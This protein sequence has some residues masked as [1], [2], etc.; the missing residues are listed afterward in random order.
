MLYRD[1]ADNHV[2]DPVY[3]PPNEDLHF[4]NN[5]VVDNSHSR[6]D[7]FVTLSCP[8]SSTANCPAPHGGPRLTTRAEIKG[9]LFVGLPT[10]VT[11][12]PNADAQF[13]VVIPYNDK[14]AL[15]I[16]QAL[17]SLWNGEQ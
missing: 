11:N 13:N 5:V 6:S 9:N 10:R 4:L 7:S 3:G 14:S 1:V 8:L 16:N 17:T 15:M 12:Q 2:K